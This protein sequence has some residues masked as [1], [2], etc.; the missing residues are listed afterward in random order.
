MASN[1][2]GE[3]SLRPRNEWRT[4]SCHSSRE[5]L[6]PVRVVQALA[7]WALRRAALQSRPNSRATDAYTSPTKGHGSMSVPP[8]SKVTASMLASDRAGDSARLTL[9]GFISIFPQISV[10]CGLLLVLNCLRILLSAFTCFYLHLA[11]FSCL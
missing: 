2:C 1:S 7:N 8:A 10:L 3:T 6:K 9:A 5:Y 4:T 11:A